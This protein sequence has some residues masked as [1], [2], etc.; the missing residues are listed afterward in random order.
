MIFWSKIRDFFGKNAKNTRKSEDF[1]ENSFDFSDEFERFQAKQ[2]KNEMKRIKHQTKLLMAKQN[3][4]M[5]K[6]QYEEL[7]G[8]DDVEY[9]YE[10]GDDF[11]EMMMKVLEKSLMAKMSQN[12]NQS[13]LEVPKRTGTMSEEDI[14]RSIWALPESYKKALKEMNFEERM[15]TVLTYYPNLS[16]ETI[17]KFFELLDSDK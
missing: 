12:N 4:A 5:M 10:E 17:I 9:E 3:L 15:K 1:S 13:T 11:E 6:Q 7:I 14:K 8:N 16:D 2:L